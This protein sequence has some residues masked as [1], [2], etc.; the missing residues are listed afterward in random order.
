MRSRRRRSLPPHPSR[1][2]APFLARRPPQQ[3]PKRLLSSVIPLLTQRHENISPTGQHGSIGF[4]ACRVCPER[5]DD[6][7][8]GRV[9]EEWGFGKSGGG[10]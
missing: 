3:R 6:Y 1:P 4:I 2:P 10:S 8:G 5:S 9:G 7:V